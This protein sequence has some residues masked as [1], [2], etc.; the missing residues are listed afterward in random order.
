MEVNKQERERARKQ[1]NTSFHYKR[2]REKRY[3]VL[4]IDWICSLNLKQIS[5]LNH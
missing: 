4:K 3:F 2:K 1:L 5:K